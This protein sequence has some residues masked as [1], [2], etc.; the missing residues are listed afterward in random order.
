MLA[1]AEQ[2]LLAPGVGFGDVHMDVLP[3]LQ[4]D[5]DQRPQHGM[6]RGKAGDQ[7]QAGLGIA[8]ARGQPRRQ[9]PDR[10]NALAARGCGQN[11]CSRHGPVRSAF[12]AQVE[13][14][15]REETPLKYSNMV[16]ARGCECYPAPHDNRPHFQHPQLLH[17]RPYRPWQID[18][19]RP[20]D[21]DDRRA[22]RSRNGGQG[23]G[24]RFHGYRARARH[25]HQGADGAA[26]LPRQGRQGL[27]LQP[28][29]HARPCRLRL[30]SLAVAGGLRGLAAGGRRQ[31]GRR[32]ADAR[33]RLPRARRGP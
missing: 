26:E 1:I 32:G 17:R 11:G 13:S 14:A 10:G 4:I 9:P 25:H 2:E 3:G 29:G 30:R 22:D 15:W 19:G 16:A 7:P 12:L 21:P 33:Q 5:Q 8:G 28:D 24:A 23:A 6:N 27:H 31:P 20:P 18:A